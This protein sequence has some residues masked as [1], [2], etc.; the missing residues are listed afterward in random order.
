MRN[1]KWI[2]ILG[3]LIGVA[4]VNAQVTAN[5]GFE[6]MKSLAGSWVL[7]RVLGNALRCALRMEF[8]HT[9]YWCHFM[10]KLFAYSKIAVAANVM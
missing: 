1:L 6:K 4:A 9:Q 2:P 7:R 3:T 10:T 5:P 8:R